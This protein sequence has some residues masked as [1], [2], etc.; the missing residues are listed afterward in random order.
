MSLLSPPAWQFLL[1]IALG[2][3]AFWLMLWC[4]HHADRLALKREYLEHAG[5][6]REAVFLA[7]VLSLLWCLMATV[8]P[9]KITEWPAVA[10]VRTT[11]VSLS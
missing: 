2:Y 4:R 11:A 3:G 7:V 8:A 1:A 9:E 6:R 10:M 5:V